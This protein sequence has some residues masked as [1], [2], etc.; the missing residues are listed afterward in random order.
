MAAGGLQ[1]AA[2]G[3]RIAVE[4]AQHQPVQTQFRAMQTFAYGYS[5]HAGLW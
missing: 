3:R 4:P 1:E 2:V 5:L